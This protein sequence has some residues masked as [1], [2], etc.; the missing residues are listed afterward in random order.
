[1]SDLIR[2]EVQDSIARIVLDRPQKLNALNRTMLTGLTQSLTAIEADPAI[3][4][5]V[6]TGRGE[7]SFCV[8]ADILEWSQLSPLDMWKSWIRSGHQI[9]NHISQ[10]AIP[11]VASLNGLALGGGLELALAADLRIAAD[12]ARLGTPEVKLGIIPGWGGTQRLAQIIGPGRAKQMIFTGDPISAETALQWGLVNEVVP[13]DQ[14]T[15]HTNA[16]AQ[17]IATNAPVAVQAAKSLI[18]ADGSL[19]D[20][21]YLEGLA[22]ALVTYTDDARA[23]VEAF[24]QRTAPTFK[25]Q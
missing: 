9:M 5:L 12:H 21:L 19:T 2:F 23:G 6:L 20:G 7:K 16:L 14:L 25:G 3:R 1:M 4:V 13:A 22:G 17:S 18:D 10:L 15:A 11:V 24:R 8:G